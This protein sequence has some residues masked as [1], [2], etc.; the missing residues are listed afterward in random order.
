MPIYLGIDPG[1]SGGIALIK[2]T[3]DQRPTLINAID[4][5]AVGQG[6]KRRVD[7]HPVISFIQDCPPDYAFI[8]RAQAMPDQ[9]SSSGFNY[10]RAVGYLECC[11]LGLGIPLE[12]VEPSKWKKAH[13]LSSKTADG[14]KLET[15][16]VKELSRQKALMLFPESAKLLARVMDHGRAESI[17]IAN[18]GRMLK[19]GQA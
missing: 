6:A 4:I 3:R 5:P 8:E 19:L 2:G 10:G 17:L 9:G 1:L 16:E 7:P 15:R 12:V 14:R 11:V 13:G 18:F